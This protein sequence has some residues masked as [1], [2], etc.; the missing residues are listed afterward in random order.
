MEVYT[1]GAC[2]GNPGPGGWGWALLEGG[3]AV[4]SDGGGEK[5]TTNNRMEL[6]AVIE[7]V[8]T[9]GPM[10]RPLVI[11]SDSKYVVGNIQ[12]LPVWEARGWKGSNK[13]PVKNP[14]L[15][16]ELYALCKQYK[17]SFRWVK[18]HSGDVG[19]EIADAIASSNA[20]RFSQ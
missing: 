16:Q 10:E 15:W 11:V 3:K 12:G 19:N 1:D 9:F 2:L 20:E 13:K 5:L 17:V 6:K 4:A 8:K 7:A 18:G 14:D